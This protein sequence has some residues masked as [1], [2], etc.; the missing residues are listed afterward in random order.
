MKRNMD[1]IIHRYEL[2]IYTDCVMYLP[3]E[4]LTLTQPATIRENGAWLYTGQ[5]AHKGFRMP[6]AKI[7]KR[8][9]VYQLFEF[10]FFPG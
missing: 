2:R 9:R 8:T 1:F 7:K 6:E 3:G 5:S 10:S 4:K